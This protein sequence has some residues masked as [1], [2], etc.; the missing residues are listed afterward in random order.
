M[1]PMQ[2]WW[3]AEQSSAVGPQVAIADGDVAWGTGTGIRRSRVGCRIRFLAGIDFLS[4]NERK[5]ANLSVSNPDSKI[6]FKMPL[7]CLVGFLY[8]IWGALTLLT[9]AKASV[10]KQLINVYVN[11]GVSCNDTIICLL[12]DYISFCSV[13][14][15]R[16]VALCFW[17]ANILTTCFHSK[18]EQKLKMGKFSRNT[19]H[20]FRYQIICGQ[21]SWNLRIWL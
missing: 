6:Q 1:H 16:R 4:D 10:N 17:S 20:V 7:F 2:I 15:R 12:C 11:F 9:R 14:L 21:Y 3:K 18:C 13:C 8:C 5:L 19:K